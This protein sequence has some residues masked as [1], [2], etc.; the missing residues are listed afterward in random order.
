MVN[1][2]FI[3]IQVHL[4]AMSI[5]MIIYVDTKNRINWQEYSFRLFRLLIVS[6]TLLLGTE[7]ASWYSSGH[8]KFFWNTACFSLHAV[9]GY[10]WS[11]YTDYQLGFTREQLKQHRLLRLLPLLAVETL[12]AVNLFFPVFFS[13]DANGVYQREPLFLLDTLLSYSYLAYALLRTYRARQQLDPVFLRPLLFFHIIPFIGG[14]LQVC[15]YGTGL[16][17]PSV[18]LSLL[19]CYIYIQNRQLGLDYLTKAFNRLQID[20]QLRS[21]I[22]SSD[23]PEISAIMI[24]INNFKGINDTFGHLVGDEALVQTAQLLRQALRH[25]D[26]LA[27]YGGDEFLIL[28]RIGS[29][30]ALQHLEDRIRQNFDQFN[31]CS[32]KPFRLT[33]SIGHG[34]YDPQSN[35]TP[36]QFL[37]MVDQEMY[38]EKRHKS[39]DAPTAST[40]EEIKNARES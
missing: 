5:C 29:E 17:W 6:C 20:Q 11:L 18:S 40:A 38:R 31:Q 10:L 27:R 22:Q 1:E 37:A 34:I 25:E 21:C 16:A 23:H 35:Q 13:L 15:Y 3:R 26:F 4:L 2:A 24:D 36:E 7:A 9:P 39:S 33:L 8:W 28:T 19:V 30:E 14:L 32:G 12:V